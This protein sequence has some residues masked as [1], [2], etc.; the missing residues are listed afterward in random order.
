[1]RFVEDR[2]FRKKFRCICN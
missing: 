2:A 1:V